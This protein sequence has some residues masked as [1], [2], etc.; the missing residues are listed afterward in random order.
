MLIKDGKEVL[1]RS[2]EHIRI[3]LVVLRYH[4]VEGCQFA[5]SECAHP[6][7]SRLQYQLYGPGRR[8]EMRSHRRVMVNSGG[9][10]DQGAIRVGE[11]RPKRRVNAP[12]DPPDRRTR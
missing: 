2:V 3:D 1:W 5:R 7:S 8:V 11:N 6:L 10:E 12:R 9:A 4:D